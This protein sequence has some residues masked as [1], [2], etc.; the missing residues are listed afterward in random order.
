MHDN[1]ITAFRDR[2]TAITAGLLGAQDGAARMVPMSH[3]MREG[4][5]TIWFITAHDTD[6]AQAA[7]QGRTPA[8]YVIGEGC[9]GLYAVI[10]GNLF[11]NYEADLLEALW[12]PV[13]DSWFEGGKNDPR[14][15]LLGLAPT[16]G[17][18]WLTPTSGLSFAFNIL[19]AQVT[20]DQPDMGRHANL[21]GDDLSRVR[22]HA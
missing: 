22:M 20:G 4:D 7:E 6:L 17:E 14:V 12:S 1:D 10:H 3:Q 16:S 21:S 19:R 2:L 9:K 15:C 13:A 18:I 11:Q 8:T 5:P